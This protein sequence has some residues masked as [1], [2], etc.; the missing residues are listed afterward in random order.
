MQYKEFLETKR[1][2]F[3]ESGFDIEETDLKLP[4]GLVLIIQINMTYKDHIKN[5]FVFYLIFIFWM[6]ANYL[7]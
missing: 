7:F 5:L 4:R 1:K 2:S 6:E 3:L